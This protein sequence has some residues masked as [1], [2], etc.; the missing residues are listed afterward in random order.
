MF[1][2]KDWDRKRFVRFYSWLDSAYISERAPKPLDVAA[3]F[4]DYATRRAR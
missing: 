2:K 3:Y 4:A 1:E